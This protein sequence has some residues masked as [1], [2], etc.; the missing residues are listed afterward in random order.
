MQ[1]EDNDIDNEYLTQHRSE[2]YE[3]ATTDFIFSGK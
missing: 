3:N 2:S 1:T